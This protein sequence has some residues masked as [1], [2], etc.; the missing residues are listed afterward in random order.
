MNQFYKLAPA[1]LFFGIPLLAQVAAPGPLGSEVP[2]LQTGAEQAVTNEIRLGV[3]ASGTFDDNALNNDQKK[4]SDI[5]YDLQ[6]SVTFLEK[7]RRLDWGFRYEPGVSF[8]PHFTSS[9]YFSQLA[10]L[11]LAYQLQRHLTFTFHASSRISS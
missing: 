7:L 11:D 6:P 1:I 2:A 5:Q 9:S 4:H 10:A 3:R 8:N